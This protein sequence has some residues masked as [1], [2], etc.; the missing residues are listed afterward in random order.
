[1]IR[2]TD[3]EG[4]ATTFAYDA[5]GRMTS[6]TDGNG[7]AVRTIYNGT[8]YLADKI[9]FPTF[10]RNMSYDVRN[11]LRTSIDQLDAHT[12]RTVRYGY[13][14]AGNRISSTDPA[15]RIT[16]Y[17]YD[18]LGRLATVTDPAGGVTTYA[19]DAQG[20]LTGVTD[21]EGHAAFRYEYDAA[22][23][24]TKELRPMGQFSSFVYDKAGRLTEKTD[25]LSHKISYGYDAAGRLTAIA[26]PAVNGIPARTVSFTYDANGNLTGYN[27]GT[28][29]G[30][31][32]YDANNQKLTDTVNY[33]SFSLSSAYSYNK[34]GQKTSFT[35]PD[36]ATITY[37]Y[38]AGNLLKNINIPG[39]GLI[40]YYS[41]NWLAPTKTILP[42]GST[43]NYAYDGLLRVTD[44][45]MQ[46][47]YANTLMHYSYAYDN[48][49]NITL[50][51][52]EHGQH[53]YGYDTLDRLVSANYPT[54][55]NETFAYDK[56]GNRI[57]HNN[58]VQNPWQYNANNE[59]L[60]RPNV[61]YTYDANGSQIQ[62]TENGITTDYL[63]NSNNRLSQI[64][65]GTTT[66][67]AYDYDPFGR[68]LSKTVNGTTIYF[69]YSDEGLTAEANS[70]GKITQS[71]GYAP[72]STWGTDPLYM[73]ING[74]YHFYL[75]D[76][77]GTPQQL[78]DTA[79]Q[80]SWAAI[81]EAFGKATT[82]NSSVSSN[83]R[84]PGQYQDLDSSFY[85]NFHRYYDPETGR[86]LSSDPIGLSGGVN[87]FSY[88][89]SNP[90]MRFDF[91]GLCECER[92][93][94]NLE[95][96]K[97]YN[98]HNKSSPTRACVMKAIYTLRIYYSDDSIGTS[99]DFFSH[100]ATIEGLMIELEKKG[101]LTGELTAAFDA[102]A[103]EN[104]EKLTNNIG[105]E[106]AD[107][108]KGFYIIGPVAGSHVL[109]LIYDGKNYQVL[110]QGT[111]Y[112][113]ETGI[114]SPQEFN[115]YVTWMTKRLPERS[116]RIHGYFK[117]FMVLGG[118]CPCP[119]E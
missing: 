7:N 24:K 111:P 29:S 89:N 58:D 13:D 84:H 28:T 3:A 69:Y 113:R 78:A 112:M 107:A 70:S 44:I 50:K 119:S 83:L 92:E 94:T 59:L 26:Y 16:R 90:I 37:A 95:L 42:G 105:K 27:D 75:N 77:L 63:Y 14:L 73:S 62:K 6:V 106:I 17:A 82:A 4:H 115:E 86:Y 10:T 19:Y 61:T 39:Q 11:R 53:L 51:N 52:T 30:S 76:H 68:R 102:A 23:R 100:D 48:V 66:I 8:D 49:G 91:S 71:Y 41:Y 5:R 98:S 55:S 57:V 65:Q 15:A 21:A 47:A 109:L 60:N 64:K 1:M 81:Y 80:Q 99:K 72:D 96:M 79:G 67:A 54:Q 104:V 93:A 118:L 9:E 38:D 12:N 101:I 103:V 32:T 34:N 20:N 18:A 33:G 56:V 110:D 40:D 25:A 2:C 97:M 36:N 22:G 31:Y 35:G 85:Y 74:A 46:D 117:S 114:K 43:K 87:A 108:G 88:G 116:D 45:H